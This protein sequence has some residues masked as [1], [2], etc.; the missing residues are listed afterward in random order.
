MERSGEWVKRMNELMRNHTEAE[1]LR[2]GYAGG[3]VRRNHPEKWCKDEIASAV[4]DIG[5]RRRRPARAG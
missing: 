5:L 3:L 1:L 2:R 4:V